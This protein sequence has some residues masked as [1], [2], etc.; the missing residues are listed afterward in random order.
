MNTKKWHICKM[1]LLQ[2]VAGNVRNESSKKTGIVIVESI[3]NIVAGPEQSK[4]N[5]E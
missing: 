3:A 2:G 5:I 4:Y 1:K